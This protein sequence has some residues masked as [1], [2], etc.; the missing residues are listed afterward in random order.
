MPRASGWGLSLD[1]LPRP[2]FSNAQETFHAKHK[3]KIIQQV[4]HQTSIVKEQSHGE[5]A[6]S[7]QQGRRKPK[8]VNNYL[9]SSPVPKVTCDQESLTGH[10]KKERTESNRNL[11]NSVQL[12]LLKV[13]NAIAIVVIS[14]L[15]LTIG[16][17]QRGGQT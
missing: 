1:A 9:I 16:R 14:W 13:T 10:M 12:D 4:A 3:Q 7:L 17:V 6:T 2:R 15:I 8:Y 5:T 11:R